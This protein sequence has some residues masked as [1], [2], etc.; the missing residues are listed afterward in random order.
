LTHSPDAEV[1]KGW[2]STLY[3][4]ERRL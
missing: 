2:Q 4:L 3:S 1:E